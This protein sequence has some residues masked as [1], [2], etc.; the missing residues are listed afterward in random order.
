MLAE[1]AL[2]AG[3]AGALVEAVA[4]QEAVGPAAAAL[5]GEA[6]AAEEAGAEEGRKTPSPR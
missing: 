5:V 1:E 3:A 2:G 6:V 4:A